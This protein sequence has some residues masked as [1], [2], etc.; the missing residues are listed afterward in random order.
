MKTLVGVLMRCRAPQSQR[1]VFRKT[2]E[3]SWQVRASEVGISLAES[4]LLSVDSFYSAAAG[5]I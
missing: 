4:V 2:L 5:S 3:R 1:A